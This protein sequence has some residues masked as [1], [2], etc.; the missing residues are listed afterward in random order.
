MIAARLWRLE[1]QRMK[2]GRPSGEPSK[3]GGDI[4][5]DRLGDAAPLMRNLQTR[6]D[7]RGGSLCALVG[8]YL[9][10]FTGTTRHPQPDHPSQQRKGELRRS[11]PLPNYFG[12]RC[13]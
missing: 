8:A 12:I 5:L 6:L 11:A 2:W 9:P 1:Y 7:V 3:C 10:T 13:T 4:R